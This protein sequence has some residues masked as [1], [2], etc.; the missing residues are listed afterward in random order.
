GEAQSSIDAVARRQEEQ[1]PES[2]KGITV[3]IMP[4]TVARPIP[5]RFLADATPVIRGFVLMLGGLVLLLACMNV[6]NLLMVRATIRDRGHGGSGGPARQRIRGLLVVGQVG[7]SLVLLIVAGLLVRN[8][9]NAQHLDL[10][11]KSS[12]VLNARFAPQWAGYDKR[13]TEDFY[14][15]LL[16]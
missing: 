8:L 2:E 9:R 4:E 16:R 3:R 10:G 12:H 5:L 7:G 11:F 1:H 13:R 15:E 6:A 14:R